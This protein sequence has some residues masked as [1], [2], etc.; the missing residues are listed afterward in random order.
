[1]LR[2]KAV[3][4]I[5]STIVLLSVTG[6]N[7]GT[8]SEESTRETPSAATPVIEEPISSDPSDSG[9]IGLPPDPGDPEPFNN[10]TAADLVA[11]IRIGWNLGNTFD[12]YDL[13]WLGDNPSVTAMETGWQPNVTSA[14]NINALSEAG[15][16]A[17][18]ITVTW[19]KAVDE[20]YIIREDWMARIREVVDYAVSND[21]YIILNSHHDESHFSMLDKDFERTK[22]YFTKLWIQI[23]GVF[24]NYNEKL[25]FEGFNEPR[26]A[27]SSMEWR[28]GIAEEHNNLN[29]LNQNFVDTVRGTGGNNDKRILIIPT[30]AASANDVALKA[31]VMPVDTVNNK[32]I[33]SIHSYA[34]WEFALKTGHDEPVE[35]SRETPGDT[36]P[37][38]DPIDH[39]HELFVSR[40]IPVI[41]GEMGALNRNNLSSRVEWAE[42]YTSYAK[43]KGIPC[44]WWDNGVSYVT[45]LREWGWEETFGIFNRGTNQ[46]DH[47]EIM[48]ALMRGTN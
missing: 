27:G 3:A 12:A 14:E 29:L 11:D 47:P 25:I 32:I 24:R 31:L 36:R 30:Y 2:K 42:F 48:E 22:D 39:A 16:N 13:T 35:W 41:M 1:M 19:I 46:F 44:F 18:R 10:I 15:F 40:G 4:I 28:G 8:A 26:T 7:G 33:V 23:A 21:M 38:T 9:F 37:I 20:N 6:C 43:S 45:I 34:P 5:I 17:I